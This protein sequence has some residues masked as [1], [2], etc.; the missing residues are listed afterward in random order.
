MRRSEVSRKTV[1]I[2]YPVGT[3]YGKGAWLHVSA[4][5]QTKFCQVDLFGREDFLCVI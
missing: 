5:Y 2:L 3:D 4:D 1:F